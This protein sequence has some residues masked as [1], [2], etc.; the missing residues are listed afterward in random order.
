[1]DF[2]DWLKEK[3][4]QVDDSITNK[5]LVNNLIEIIVNWMNTT[6]DVYCNT[7]YNTF[8]INFYKYIYLGINNKRDK[9]EFNDLYYELKYND[10][11]V[12]LYLEL[13]DFMNSQGS[14]MFQNFGSYNLLEFLMDN[15]YILEE[16]LQNNENDEILY[17]EYEMY[18]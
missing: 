6:D 17:Y 15:T 13:N 1:M 18:K 14:L 4:I 2:L 10:D 7:D 5:Y 11:V 9:L 3:P 12:C 16:E 8:K